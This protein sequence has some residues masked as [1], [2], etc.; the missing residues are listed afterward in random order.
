MADERRDDDT[1]RSPVDQVVDYCVLAPLGFALEAR[2]LLPT[3]IER[4][5]SQVGVAK[6][7]GEFAVK[8]GSTRVE[9][10]VVDAQEQAMGLLRLTGLAPL[11]ERERGHDDARARSEPAD[12][13]DR[14]PLEPGSIGTVSVAPSDAHPVEA[15]VVDEG[16]PSIE[17]DSLAIPDYDN[18]SASQVLPRLDG[19]E[20]SELEAVGRYERDHRGRKTILNRVAQLEHP[21]G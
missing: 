19:L 14:P 21:D 18:L 7:V 6:M 10:A 1:P 13:D 2:S 11:D 17:V 15:G 3:F 9:S 4:G 16:G 5:R 12:A 20:P 8:W